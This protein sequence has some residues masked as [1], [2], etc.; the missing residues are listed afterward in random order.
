VNLKSI[1]ILILL[2]ITL[3]F[4]VSLFAEN[5][6]MRIAIMDFSPKGMSVK[7][8]RTISEL[9]RNDMINTGEYIVVERDQMNRILYEQGFQMTGCTDDSCAVQAGKLLAANKILVGSI[10][11][12]DE[13]IIITGRIV[14]VEK[15]TAEFSEKDTTE[16]RDDL[17]RTAE[18]FVKR[19][20]DRMLGKKPEPEKKPRY[21]YYSTGAAD[22]TYQRCGYSTLAFALAAGVTAIPAGAYQAR[23]AA[24]KREYKN[25]KTMFNMT[26]AFS[27]SG[28]FQLFNLMQ[29]L[30]MKKNVSDMKSAIRSRDTSLYVLAGFGGLSVIMAVA[31][32]ATYVNSEYALME[33][34]DSAP[35]AVYPAY[36]CEPASDH[37]TAY[38]HRFNVMTYYRF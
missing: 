11:K 7:D 26:L 24:A 5:K 15:G 17:D 9:I 33:R 27:G 29:A 31:T 19:L 4:N 22:E 14:D 28:T 6:K 2:I 25:N 13:K 3:P 32:L 8:A 1:I 34:M 10:I 21:K 37:G 12:L 30:A 18:R 20:T 35:F 38:N 36:Y 23:Y 16:T